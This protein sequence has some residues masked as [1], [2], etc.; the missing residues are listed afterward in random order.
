MR[1][2]EQNVRNEASAKVSAIKREYHQ[3]Q[4]ELQSSIEA[5]NARESQAKKQMD[6]ESALIDARAE[7]KV[8][9]TQNYLKR[10]YNENAEKQKELHESRMKELESNYKA[11]TGRLYGLT[12]GGVLYSLLTTIFTGI[13]SQRF[14]SDLLDLFK[15]IGN[16]FIMLWENSSLL[17]SAA[18][19][20]NEKIPYIAI[21]VIISG[22]LAVLGFLALF[23]GVPALVI[24][25]LYK[26]C[27]FYAK[28][29]ADSLSV[30]VA[31]VSLAL[32][33]WF[34]DYLSFVTWNL[35]VVFIIS[36]GIYVLI[37]MLLT[38]SNSY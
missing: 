13:N 22:L 4:A 29:F 31:L 26:A 36:Q 23:I 35:I 33:V 8:S 6:E 27:K 11:K 20:L 15:F 24:F 9:R 14:S 30:L 1:K 10:K 17:A 5:A 2:K 19:S 7:A 21:D 25:G 32:L 38:S 37:R 3:K 18:W 28:F 34:A 16:F 12:I